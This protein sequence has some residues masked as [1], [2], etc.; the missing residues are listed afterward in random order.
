MNTKQLWNALMTN[1]NTTSYFDGVFSSDMLE[2]IVMKPKLIICNTDPSY[3]KGEHWVLFYFD[4]EIVEFYDSS[5]MSILKYKNFIKFGKR[6]ALKYKES[7]CRTQPSNTDICGEMCLFYAYYRCK[8][9]NM[10][11]I[12]NKMTN[13]KNLVTFVNSKFNICKNSKCKLLQCCIKI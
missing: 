11:F 4:N 2:D 9:Y 3:R 13:N 8:G 1:K 7:T 10:D 12:L 6:Y 5:G